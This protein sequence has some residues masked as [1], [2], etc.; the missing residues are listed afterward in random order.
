MIHGKLRS[1]GRKV[2]SVAGFT[3]IELITVITIIAILASIAIP[4]YR[5]SV[6]RAKEAALLENLY[7]MRDALDK[8]YADNGEYPMTLFELIEKKYT[9]K[10]PVD[11]FTGSSDTWVVEYAEDGGIFDVRSGSDGVGRNGIPY[12]EL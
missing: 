4:M 7:Q 9:R 10:I 12:N 1:P 2:R 11:P 8:Y 6:T 5:N 3:L